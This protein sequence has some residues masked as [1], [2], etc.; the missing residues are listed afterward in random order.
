MMEDV[1]NIENVIQKVKD[2]FTINGVVNR[3]Y[4]HTLGVI[5]KALQLNEIHH[6]QIDRKKII[7]ACA[8]HDI[9]KFL[10]KED[11]R[12]KIQENYNQLYD[13]LSLYPEIWHSFVGKIYAKDKYNIIDEEILNAIEYHTTGRPNMTN[14]EKIVF[15]SD[16]IEE[17]TREGIYLDIPRKL[18]LENINVCIMVI[19]EQTINYLECSNL[20]VFSLTKETYKYY[21]EVVK[22]YV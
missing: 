15:I 18:S 11:M 9:A 8:F 16:Y 20:S 12:K 3:R 10:P 14:L 7:L 22:Q 5:E 6:L 17:R 13:E 2:E 1:N 4:Q 21:K 19:L